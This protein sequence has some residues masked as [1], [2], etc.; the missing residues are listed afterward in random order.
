MSFFS[1]CG[2]PCLRKRQKA[3]TK[4]PRSPDPTH[5]TTTWGLWELPPPTWS[6]LRLVANNSNSPPIHSGK[7]NNDVLGIIG[8]DLKKFSL[9]NNLQG[10]IYF[11][12]QNDQAQDTTVLQNYRA[13]ELPP[14][15]G[16][17]RDQDNRQGHLL[18]LQ[19]ETLVHTTG[20]NSVAFFK[21]SIWIWHYFF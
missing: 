2:R 21:G 14:T 6:H 15:T 7:T 3:D 9:I 17:T 8:H 13:R 4:G 18:P 20:Y 19:G 12:V 16:S 11:W 5:P 1:G 10:S